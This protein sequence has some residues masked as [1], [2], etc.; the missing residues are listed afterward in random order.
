MSNDINKLLKAVTGAAVD[1]STYEPTDDQRRAKSA[2]WAAVADAKLVLPEEGPDLPLV[3]RI[4][5]D[6]KLSIW[7]GIPGFIPWFSNKQEFLQRVDFIANLALDEMENILRSNLVTAQVK[8]PLIKLAMELGGKMP[9]LRSEAP[10][11][12]DEVIDKMSR[13][14]LE[15]YISKKMPV[16][17]P[18]SKKKE[19]K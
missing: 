5:S 19:E 7:W 2:F 4:V 17:V 16:L 14:E 3:S 12:D 15:E 18:T 9:K 1:I 10:E 13:A 6:T 11:S 8:S